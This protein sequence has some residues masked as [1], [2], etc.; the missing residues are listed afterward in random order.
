MDMQCEAAGSR[1][2]TTRRSPFRT[3]G[4]TTR[5]KPNPAM[6]MPLHAVMV[7]NHC[8]RKHG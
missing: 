8:L 4:R 1:A 5:E 3:D 6:P 2:L 7:A